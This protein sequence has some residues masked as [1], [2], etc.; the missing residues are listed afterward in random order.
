MRN[1]RN[2]MI[3]NLRNFFLYF[4]IPKLQETQSERDEEKSAC[5]LGD[6]EFSLYYYLR[7]LRR[8]IHI[9]I[10]KIVTKKNT[11]SR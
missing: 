7:Q 2:L 11:I 1:G 4:L 5:H 3:H 10:C 9:H 6:D 8:F